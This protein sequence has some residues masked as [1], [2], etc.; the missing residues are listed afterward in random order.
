VSPAAQARGGLSRR[1]F[2]FRCAHLAF[3][4]FHHLAIFT[5]HDIAFLPVEVLIV[6]MILHELLE[7]RARREKLH[8]LSMV[9]AAFFSEVGA[10][11]L[12]R[13]AVFDAAD[14]TVREAFLAE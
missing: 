7:R 11:L 8:K 9:I 10:E 1:R 12:R 4:D 13:I 2:A 6:T 14:A 3:R 5:L